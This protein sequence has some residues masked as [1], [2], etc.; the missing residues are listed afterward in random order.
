[1]FMPKILKLIIIFAFIG[2][3]YFS[4]A[5]DKADEAF[6]YGQNPAA[7]KYADINGIKFYYEIYGDGAP[8]V[9][10][11]GNGDSIGGLKA[12]I[13]YFSKKY[14]VIVADSRGHGK[15]GL[16]TAPLDYDQMME[17]WNELLNH[18]D[19]KQPNIFGW[20]D[21]GILGLLLAIKHP[22]K[23]GKLAIM[24]ANLRPDETAVQ[25]WV[26]PIL[27]GAVQHVEEMI[28][29][30]DTSENWNI[31]RQLLNLLMTQPNIDTKSL[32]QIKVPV[33]VIAG[34]RDVIKEE[35]TIEIFQNLE[36]AHL[37]ILPGQTH[38]API[39]D[40]VMFNDLLNR[41][42][43]KPFTKPTTKEIM[44]QH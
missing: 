32:K 35:H 33:L 28:K 43:E 17:D 10:I 14:M 30:K 20:S 21:G 4:Y 7:G 34:D 1:M 15:S 44:E 38:F 37:A 29:K 26:K 2:M 22:E 19:V 39:T 23:V 16:G 40:P 27:E 18:L 42:F 6:L 13:K 11:H 25:S 8:L 31:Q 41:F 5:D 12:Q 3:P 36:N 24:G 9:L